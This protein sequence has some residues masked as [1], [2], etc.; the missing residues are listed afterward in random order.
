MVL[1]LIQED[2]NHGGKL[3]TPDC[4][5][6]D[7]KCYRVVTPQGIALPTK[8]IGCSGCGKS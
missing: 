6:F 8:C 7:H 4:K 2:L 3:K 5:K 1:I